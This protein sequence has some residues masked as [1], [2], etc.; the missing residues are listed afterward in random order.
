MR[1]LFA[2]CT[3]IAL[4]MTGHRRAMVW[5]LEIVPPPGETRR[6]VVERVRRVAGQVDF[7]N[8]HMARDCLRRASM[9]AT[10]SEME[11]NSGMTASNWLFV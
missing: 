2:V 4:P 3:A 11:R 10:K 1:P 7:R 6:V 9:I 5:R 8:G